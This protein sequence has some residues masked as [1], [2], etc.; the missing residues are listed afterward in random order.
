KQ[1]YHCKV[2]IGTNEPAV[3]SLLAF[4]QATKRN[5]PAIEV[6][7]AVYA[8]ITTECPD[9]EAELVC[10]NSEQKSGGLG[11]LSSDGYVLTVPISI[12]RRL[13][14][15]DSQVI[16]TLG[17]KYKFEISCGMNGRIWIRAKNLDTTLTIVNFIESLEHIPK[18][19]YQHVADQ[20][21]QGFEPVVRQ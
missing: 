6:G 7:D 9:I 1:A 4:P 10:V 3:L 16:R 14:A 12:V 15:P 19:Q 20:L 13:L 8:Q 21:V 2:D 18:C 17:S 5:K 11:V